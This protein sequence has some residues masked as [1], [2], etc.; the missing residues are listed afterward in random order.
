[1]KILAEKKLKANYCR[2]KKWQWKKVRS[3]I[4]IKLN[5]NSEYEE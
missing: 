1:M 4:T 5:M 2:N 3:V